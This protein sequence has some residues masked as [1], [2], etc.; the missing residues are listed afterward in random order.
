VLVDSEPI[1]NRV[2]AGL[3]TDIGLPMTPEESIDAFM[4]RSWKTVEAYAA[5]RRGEPL[6]EGFRRRYLDAMFAAF[7]EQLRPVPGV[8]EALDAIDLPN[9]VASSGSHEKMRFTLG[10]TGLLE[11]FGGRIF[12]ATEVEHGKPA[13]DL[14]LYAAERMGWA[15]AD[16]AVVED[17]PAGV[18]S[19]LAAGMTAFG[20]AGTTPAARLTQPTSSAGT[21]DAL[22]V[23][24]DMA[25]LPALLQSPPS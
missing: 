11:R 14:F 10:H 24:T 8:V 20:Y 5:E 9:C 7:G 13:P 21:G 19:A 4:G 6:P 23:F 2:L 16:C 3:L 17:S 1:S 25:E 15:P 12:S 18:E 22:H